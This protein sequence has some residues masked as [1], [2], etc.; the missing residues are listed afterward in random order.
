MGIGFSCLNCWS[1]C[2]LSCQENIEAGLWGGGRS[3]C[4]R[5]GT[6]RQKCCVL[7]CL[8]F[9]ELDVALTETYECHLGCGLWPCMETLKQS[10]ALPAP[11]ACLN[12]ALVLSPLWCCCLRTAYKADLSL[13]STVI[14]GLVEILGYVTVSSLSY[15]KLLA[16]VKETA[17]SLSLTNIR[18]P[19]GGSE[20]LSCD[21]SC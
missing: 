13:Y 5:V 1:A 6:V 2:K 18:L 9:P 10:T 21:V 20:E 16:L 14:L 19:Q 17:A 11:P 3:V 8:C 7:N 4:L 15:Q 12:A